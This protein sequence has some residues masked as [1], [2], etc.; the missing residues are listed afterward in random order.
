MVD[1]VIWVPCRRSNQGGARAAAAAADEWATLGR[2]AARAAKEEGKRLDRGQ[3]HA[4]ELF[5]MICSQ[6]RCCCAELLRKAAAKRSQRAAQAEA[7]AQVAAAAQRKKVR[8]CMHLAHAIR[9]LRLRLLS[10]LARP[11]HRNAGPAR[12]GGC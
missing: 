9:L 3:E 1:G 5:Q 4:P 10:S 2:W 12:A 11:P 7:A 6:V 8:A